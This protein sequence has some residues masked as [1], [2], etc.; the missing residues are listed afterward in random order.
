M[1]L[2][3]ILFVVALVC[4]ML[5]AQDADSSGTSMSGVF[6]T[7]VMGGESYTELR[8]LPE[9]AFGKVGIGLDIDLLIDKDGNIRKEDWDEFEDYINKVY[10][11]RYGT[12]QD[13]VYGKIGGFTSYT[14]GHGLIM[15]NYTNMLR[16]PEYRQIGLQLGCNL[17]LKGLGVEVFSSNITKNEILAARLKATPLDETGIPLLK[18]TMFGISYAIDKNQVKGLMDSDNDDYPDAFDDYPTDKHKWNEVDESIDFYRSLYVEITGSDAGFDDW[19]WNESNTIESLRNP[20][21]DDLGKKEISAY[22]LDY[23]VP[24]ISE[25]LFTLSHYGEVARI[26]GH[27]MGFIFPGFYTKFLIFEGNLEFRYYQDDFEPSFFDYL[28][29]ENRARMDGEN[30]VVKSD[31]IEGNSAQRGWYASVTTNIFHFL[32]FRAAYEDMYCSK[33]GNDNGKSIWAS[34]WLDQKMIPRLTTA[35]IDYSQTRVR[36]VFEH[37]RTPTTTIA[38]TAGWG[39]SPNTELFARYQERYIDADANGKI[40]GTDEVAKTVSFGVQIQF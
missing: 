31:Y 22:S 16:Y 3:A 5:F 34:A 40:Q 26:I 13:P 39:L 7:V 18:D 9:I 20:S 15:N 24:L 28:Y 27:N 8:L 2:F 1:R 11:L 37:M 19:F 33:G 30:V 10:Y 6:G 25:S 36:Y 14:L 21:F 4:P 12:R 23:E 35:R 17:P 29:E 38:G 32:F